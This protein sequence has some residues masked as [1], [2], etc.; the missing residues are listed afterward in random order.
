MEVVPK[1]PP[2]MPCRTGLQ[3]GDTLAAGVRDAMLHELDRPAF[4]EII[5]RRAAAAAAAR[6]PLGWEHINL[7]GDYTWRWLRR[8]FNVHKISGS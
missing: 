8:T 6:S 3:P 2:C 7:I 1:Q 4:V 5:E